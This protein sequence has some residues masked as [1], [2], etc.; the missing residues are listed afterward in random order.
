MSRALDEYFAALERLKSKRPVRLAAGTKIS[1]DA[2]ALEA[3]RK[4]GSI[5]KSRTA[6]EALI[7]AIDVAAAEQD[8]AGCSEDKLARAKATAEE[9]RG[10]YEAALAREVSLVRELYSTRQLLAKLTGHKVVP[11]RKSEPTS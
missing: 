6:F 7:T 2:V 10:K 11:L 3:G 8:Q 1:N 5:K 4:K 9:Y